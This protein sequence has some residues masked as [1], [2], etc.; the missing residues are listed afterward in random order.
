MDFEVAVGVKF[1]TSKLR[2]ILAEL[3][4]SLVAVI[5]VNTEGQ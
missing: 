5:K 1:A 2:G 4:D 3:E